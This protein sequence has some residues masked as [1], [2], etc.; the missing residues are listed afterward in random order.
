MRKLKSIDAIYNEVK[1][2]CFVLT[3]DAPLATALNKL[4][5]KPLIGPFAMTPRQVAVACSVDVMGS[6]VWGELKVIT[7]IC[8]ENPEL[9]LRYV[10]GEV[11]KIKE[12]RQYTKDVGKHMFTAS[13]KK[14]YESWKAIPT[15][16]A[17]MDRFDPST[18]FYPRLHGR[19]AV[20]GVDM[21]DDLDKC[22]IPPDFNYLDVDIFE[23]PGL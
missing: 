14:V 13:S 10:H 1:D 5:D 19:I 3:N 22:M 2:C 4:V 12:I 6:P 20:V 8:K 16:E 15:V 23:K 9:D 17:V 21:F 11:Q 7:T 18:T